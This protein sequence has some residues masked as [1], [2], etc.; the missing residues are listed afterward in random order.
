MSKAKR[1]VEEAF[2]SE[3]RAVKRYALGND[4]DQIS[5]YPLTMNILPSAVGV[6]RKRM[7]DDLDPSE[8]K[9]RCARVVSEEVTAQDSAC[10]TKRHCRH[11]EHEC[12]PDRL[13]DSPYSEF[14]RD[15]EE[16]SDMTKVRLSSL[17]LHSRILA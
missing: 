8:H 16:L 13:P 12:C 15:D 10:G 1:K 6:S 4:D 7:R 5:S 14:R 2:S 9:S 17:P 3:T 11:E